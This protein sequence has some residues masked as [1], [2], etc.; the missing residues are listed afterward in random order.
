MTVP[1][2]RTRAEFEAWWRAHG[3]EFRRLSVRTPPRD[4]DKI[5]DPEWL[6]IAAKIE[7]FNE[8]CPA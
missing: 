8:R 3:A 1:D 6:R 5:V 4:Y 2:W 7:A